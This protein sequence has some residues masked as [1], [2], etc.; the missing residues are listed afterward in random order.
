MNLY[1]LITEENK[2]EI[3][4]AQDIDMVYYSELHEWYTTNAFRNFSLK[5]VLEDV[6]RYKA[7][8]YEHV[9]KPHH[10]LMAMQQPHVA[11]YFHSRSFVKSICIDISPRTVAEVFSVLSDKNDPELDNYMA[12]YFRYPEFYESI[13]TL[14][15]SPAGNKL[16]GLTAKIKR[17]K[18]NVEVS[19][20]WIFDL[21]E[22]VVYQE[23]SHFSKLQNIHSVKASTRKE[24]YR[25]VNEGKNFIDDNFRQITNVNQIAKASMMSEYFFLRSFRNTFRCTPYQYLLQKKLQHAQDLLREGELSIGAIGEQCGFKDIYTFSKAFKR[26]FGFSPSSVL[27]TGA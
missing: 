11:A 15:D 12:G 13:S 19:K 4:K 14:R 26:V 10:F 25:R 16:M 21:V 8:G 20:T 24:I 7:G 1:Q 17:D 23:Y 27:K 5:C 18:Y 3:S 22:Q 9:V 6:I 2:L